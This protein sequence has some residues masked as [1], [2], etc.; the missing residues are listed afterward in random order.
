VSTRPTC[1]GLLTAREA[2]AFLRISERNLHAKTKTLQVPHVRLGRRVL[3]PRSELEAWIRASI[4][5]PGGDGPN[6]SP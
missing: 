4:Q 1:S 5:G 6:V 2:A 3:Y